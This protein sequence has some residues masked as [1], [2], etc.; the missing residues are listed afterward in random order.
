[1]TE[2]DRQHFLFPNT[3]GDKVS[4]RNMSKFVQNT[5]ITEL[6]IWEYVPQMALF[7]IISAAKGGSHLH[8]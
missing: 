1:M 2:L 4:H 7:S 8:S 3:Q 5:L 6:Q